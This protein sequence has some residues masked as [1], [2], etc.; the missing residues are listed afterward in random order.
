MIDFYMSAG[1]CLKTPAPNLQEFI[2]S[3]RIEYTKPEGAGGA[4][5]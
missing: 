2:N 4:T 3:L 5:D 1:K